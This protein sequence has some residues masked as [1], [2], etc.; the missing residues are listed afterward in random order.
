[1]KIIYADG[2]SLGNPGEAGF[3]VVALDS[4]RKKVWEFGEYLGKKTNNQAELLACIFVLKIILKS[5]L[6]KETV[7]EK[8]A[9]KQNENTGNLRENKVKQINDKKYEIRLDSQYVIKGATMWTKGWVKNNWLNS[10]KKPV[11]NKELWEQILYLKNEIENND[12]KILW[13]HVYGHKGEIWNER[14]D[15]IARSF[16]AQNELK[17][18]TGEKYI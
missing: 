9:R 16:A 7:A 17:L 1:M 4:E 14:V 10:Q 18:R 8:D 12:I 15:E 6:K 13:S 5:S 11:E 3:G 2:S